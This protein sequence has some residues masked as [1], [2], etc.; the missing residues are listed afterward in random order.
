M[1]VPRKHHYLS[2]FYLRG[3]SSNGRS[4]CQIEKRSGRAYVVSIRDAAAIRDYHELDYP[5]VDDPNAVEKGLAEIEGP[6][7]EGLAHA[8]RLGI[9]TSKIHSSVVE[10][11]TLLRVRAPAFR[12][13]IEAFLQNVVRSAGEMLER[14]GGFPPAPPGLDDVL[15]MENLSIEISNWKILE[16]MFKIAADSDLFDVLAGMRPTILR[17][18]EGTFFLTCDQPVA[19]FH[20]TAS[21]TDTYGVGLADLATEVSVPLSS[22]ALLRLSWTINP[23]TERDETDRVAT[24][25]EV[26]E[27]NR[28]TMIMANSLVFAPELSQWAVETT[29]RQR[30]C[31]AGIDLDVLD[32]GSGVAHLGRFRP[33]MRPDRYKAPWT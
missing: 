3:F 6:L 31:F 29:S 28:R 23:G 4:I 14:S 1:S 11:V 26:V 33:V 8:L 27:F 9:V 24:T 12:A 13:S 25:D 2:Q 7:A 5:G 32:A 22:C 30:H 10:L 15:R 16:F 20:P 21:P 17:A 18:P 19:I